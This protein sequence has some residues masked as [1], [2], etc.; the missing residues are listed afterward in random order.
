VTCDMLSPCFNLRNK[1]NHTLGLFTLS[2]VSF[3][4]ISLTK[5]CPLCNT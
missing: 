1:S 5:E 2:R 3:P 4:V